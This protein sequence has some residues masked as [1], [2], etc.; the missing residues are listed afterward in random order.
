MSEQTFNL[1]QRQF[2]LFDNPQIEAAKARLSEEE[3]RAYERYGELAMA[4]DYEGGAD[5]VP[6]YQK[7]AAKAYIDVLLNGSCTLEQMTKEELD[8]I[9]NVYGKDWRKLLTD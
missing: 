4:I 8:V 9:E 7:T 1:D 2:D 6:S 5:G 3:R